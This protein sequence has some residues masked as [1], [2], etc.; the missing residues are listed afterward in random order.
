[1]V[2]MAASSA[3]SDGRELL[4][5]LS[6]SMLQYVVHAEL[7]YPPALFEVPLLLQALADDQAADARSLAAALQQQG[8]DVHLPMAPMEFADLHYLSWEHM[9]PRLIVAET[10][11]TA[12]AES[13]AQRAA[14][15]DSKQVTATPSQTATPTRTPSSTSRALAS[16]QLWQQTLSHIA[17]QQQRRLQ[18]LRQIGVR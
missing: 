9:R 14:S 11:L 16:Q 1:M 13:M 17:V 12:V 15:D 7:W 6:R 8:F 3:V 2:S 5:R 10:Q 4:V 18:E